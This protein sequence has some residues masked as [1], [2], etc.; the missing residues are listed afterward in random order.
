MNK[1]IIKSEC[2]DRGNLMY[3]KLFALFLNALLVVDLFRMVTNEN[4]LIVNIIQYS[5]YIG[6][7]LYIYWRIAIYDNFKIRRSFFSFITIA[8][9]VI[10]WS[11]LFTPGVSQGYA[12]FFSFIITR[13]I[14]A[15]YFLV[16]A[17]EQKI[18]LV[19]VYLDK[20]RFVWLIYAMIG[21]IWIPAHT[22]AWNQYSMTYGYNLLIPVCLTFYYFV[23]RLKIEYLLY[24]LFFATMIM[25]RGARATLLCFFTFAVFA[26]IMIRREKLNTGKIVRA[27]TITIGVTILFLNFNLIVTT[28][29][30]MFP[31]SRTLELLT[32]NFSFDSGR[33]D[34]INEYMKEISKHPFRF[35]GIFS[36]R[37]YYSTLHGGGFNMTNYPHNFVVELFFQFGIPLGVLILC[38]LFGMIFKSVIYLNGN[39]LPEEVCLFLI[40]FVSGIL[41]LFFSASYLTS[42]EFFLFLGLIILLCKKIIV[43]V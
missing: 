16:K 42:V 43:I 31:S 37:V 21:A 9:G 32:N 8:I 30:S 5:I 36:D 25:V 35:R 19:F 33:S 4:D 17:D 11:Y 3:S 39:A 24:T 7:A 13:I 12:Y 6:I 27:F 41:K 18:C 23:K 22:N 2:E 20:Y 14:P 10:F 15:I 40:L 28:L 26:Y 38:M 34:I 29:S 1:Y